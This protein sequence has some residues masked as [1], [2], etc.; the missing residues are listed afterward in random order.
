[1]LQLAQVAIL[2]RLLVPE[3]FGLVSMVGVALTFGALFADLGLN[4]AYVQKQDVTQEQRSSI[5]WLN[6]AMSIGVTIALITISP[7]VAWYF[8]DSRL[9]PL[10]M[11]SA[12]T[13][14]ISAFGQQVRMAAE[15]QLN[16][17]PVA[18]LD[19]CAA[20]LGF[21][22][23]VVAAFAGWGV[24]SLVTGSIVSAMA[25]TLLAWIF[26][27]QAWRPRLRFR[28]DEVRPYIGF[29]GALVGNNIVNQLNASIDLLLGGRMLA[30]SQ[31]GLYS[32]P[33]NLV[34]QL[35]FTVNPIITRVAFPLIAHVQSDLP[36]VR[37]IYLQTL[38][39]TASTNAPLYVGLAFFAPEIVHL[40][41][42]SDWSGS[43][44]FLRILAIWGF[45]RST[46]NPVGA[47][48]LGMGRADLSLKWNL[49]MLFV[50]LPLLW[51]ASHSGAEGIAWA[52]LGFSIIMFIPGWYVLVR[53]LC[54]AGLLEYTK[55]A[56][57]SFL[58]AVLAVA[59]AYMIAYQFER[60]LVRLIVGIT[61]AAPLYMAISFMG[62]RNWVLAMMELAGRKG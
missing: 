57:K 58:L 61:V 5:F 52:L 21:M 35:Q 50:L 23:A 6:I 33:R 22:A 41:L 46:G 20:F 10:M 55:S 31:L 3:D 29:G 62:N 56:L 24:Y 28:I 49:T 53:P 48:L 36:R 18:L 42:G 15:K 34:L 26:L 2:A 38:N 4:S 51:M 7:L 54:H 27:A 25:G 32:I 11:L 37:L 13:L 39:M 40:L 43:V 1:L 9:S 59:P 60:E 19:V 8:S 30:A 17:R 45:F 16:F 47:L 12:I 14:V 44:D